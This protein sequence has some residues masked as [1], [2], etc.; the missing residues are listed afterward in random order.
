MNIEKYLLKE[1]SSVP[2]KRVLLKRPELKDIVDLEK[3][4][5]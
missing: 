4:L 3:L 1:D 2:A 5:K